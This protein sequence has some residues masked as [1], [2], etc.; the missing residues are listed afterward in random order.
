MD[1]KTDRILEAALDLFVEY[2]FHGTP[3]SKIAAESGVS[4]GTLF[5]YFKTKDDLI[6]S[7]YQ[8]LKAEFNQYLGEK[9]GKGGKLK[10]RFR[11]MFVN[12]V[13]WG[14]EN[15]K[16]FF[17]IQQFCYS[18]HMALI[19]ETILEEQYH[20][21]MSLFDEG[22]EKNLFKPYPVDMLCTLAASQIIGMYQYLMEEKMAPAK[23]KKLLNEA[24]ELTWSMLTKSDI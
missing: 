3:T 8:H 16:K 13:L 2:G 10:E 15:H 19:P 5:H 22:R 20:L 17:F 18:P 9:T 21:Y 7:L 1:K 23:Q 14:M 24:F 11:K 12:A 4:N 6:V